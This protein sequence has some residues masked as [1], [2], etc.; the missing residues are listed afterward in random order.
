MCGNS[1]N[2][3]NDCGKSTAGCE[4]RPYHEP[5][6]RETNKRVEAGF[7]LPLHVVPLVSAPEEVNQENEQENARE[8]CQRG[9]DADDCV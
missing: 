4:N 9:E 7:S 5:E 8:G 6:L 3:S 2:R 1:G